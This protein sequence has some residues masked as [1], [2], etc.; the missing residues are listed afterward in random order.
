MQTKDAKKSRAKTLLLMIMTVLVS[1]SALLLV[2]FLRAR[3]SMSEQ[4]E[5]NY[6]VMA[7]K[8]AQ[9]LSSWVN[10]KARLVDAIAASIT[11]SGKNDDTGSIPCLSCGNL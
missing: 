11:V 5:A 10:S 9:E 3:S 4:L 7:D 6:S 8:Y 1:V 2:S